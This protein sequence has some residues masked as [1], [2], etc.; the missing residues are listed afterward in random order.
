MS[1]EITG[2]V[3][4]VEPIV[5]TPT[6]LANQFDIVDV[7]AAKEFMDNYQELVEIL[8]DESDYQQIGDKN[9]KKKSA[10]R[11]L[12]TA[13]NISD[14][15]VHEE[16]TRDETGQIVTS[17]FYVQATLPN[18]RTATAVGVCSIY[19]KIRYHGDKRDKTQ[20]ANFE[21]RGRFSN[22]EHDVPSTAHTRAKSRAIADLIG[23]GEVS[24][25]EMTG[26]KK[27]ARKTKKTKK[28]KKSVPDRPS[29]P[30]T[31]EKETI[32]A[33]AE[34]VEAEL[35][36]NEE[37]KRKNIKTLIG[38]YSQIETA[39]ANLKAKKTRATRETIVSELLQM[40]EDGEITLD[41][42]QIAKKE[43]IE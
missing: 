3:A 28:V 39:V 2:D 20:P 21:L 41:E 18:G 40:H 36:Q 5:P 31:V 13:F 35:V 37:P 16:E 38:E 25:E 8:L 33:K 7:S 11:K 1:E 17:K 43:L 23:A 10:W 6:P 34:V 24:A 19:D 26:E 32:P 30:K 22:A 42:Y 29:K 14:K 4:V 15:I 9:A 27:S 12:A